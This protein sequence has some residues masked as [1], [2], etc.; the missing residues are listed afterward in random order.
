MVPEV[1]FLVKQIRPRTPQIDNLRAPIPILLQTRAFEAV[2]GI[3][4]AFAATHN[5]FVLIVA[6]AALVADARDGSG[7][8]VRVA[9]GAFPVAFV[10]ETADGDARCFAAHDEIRVVARH[11]CWLS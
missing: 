1:L 10:A 2:K 8:D 9:H 7:P 6:E 4:D 5:T 3:A 11:V